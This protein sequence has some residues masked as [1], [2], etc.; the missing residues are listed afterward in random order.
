MPAGPGTFWGPG[1][2]RLKGPGIYGGPG[3]LGGREPLRAL[4]TMS[5]REPLRALWPLEARGL[6]GALTTLRAQGPSL[7]LGTFVGPRTLGGPGTPGAQ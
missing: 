7:G 5:A 1:I 4:K 6:L 3:F 2:S